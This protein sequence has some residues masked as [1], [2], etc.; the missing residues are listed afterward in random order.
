MVRAGGYWCEFRFDPPLENAAGQVFRF[1]L[2][3]QGAN[4]AVVSVR[5]SSPPVRRELRLLNRLLRRMGLRLRGGAAH[6]RMWY[7]R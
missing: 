7:T 4:G 3:H 1:D 5:Q 2:T 6:A